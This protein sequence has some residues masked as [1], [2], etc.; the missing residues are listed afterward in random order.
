MQQQVLLRTATQQAACKLVLVGPEP[1]E[2]AGLA[3]RA[4]TYLGARA[5]ISQA[6][7]TR[8]LFRRLERQR[9][10]LVVV[11]SVRDLGETPLGMM[12]ALVRLH[13]AGSDLMTV[14]GIEP[15]ASASGAFLVARSFLDTR[16]DVGRAQVR[17]GLRRAKTDQISIGRPRI[18]V[19]LAEASALRAS[20]RSW[21]EI[22]RALGVSTRTVRRR[23]QGGTDR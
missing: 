3:E 22:S 19:D 7:S 5:E 4:R 18:Q 13:E 21:R 9:A 6:T 17:R 1:V 20:G 12:R 10:D 14:D 16:R 11:N 8:T 2:R 15:G 23:L